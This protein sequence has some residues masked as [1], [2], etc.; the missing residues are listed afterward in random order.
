[1]GFGDGLQLLPEE[2]CLGLRSVHALTRDWRDR[3]MT[4]RQAM[5]AA[6]HVAGRML[7]TNT[8]EWRSYNVKS[9]PVAWPGGDSARRKVL[10]IPGSLNEVWGHPD[11]QSAWAQPTDGYDAIIDHFSLRQEELVLRCHPNWGEYIGKTTGD[12]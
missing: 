2:S 9:R 1:T 7:R 8:K 10:L 3:P 11:W 4:S 6:S 5:R 12:K